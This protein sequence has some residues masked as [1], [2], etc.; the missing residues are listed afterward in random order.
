M[1]EFDKCPRIQKWNP[2]FDTSAPQEEPV[3]LAPEAF[4]FEEQL[5][6]K[7]SHPG[8]MVSFNPAIRLANQFILNTKRDLEESMKRINNIYDFDRCTSGCDEAFSMQIGPDS[9]PIAMT[10]HQTT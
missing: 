8:M 9:I 6:Q 4:A 10:I 2:E 3:R 5:L 1:P 7:E